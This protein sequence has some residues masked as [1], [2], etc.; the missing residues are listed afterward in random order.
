MSSK[1]RLKTLPQG[2]PYVSPWPIGTRVRIALWQFV[3]LF[4]Y[5]PTPKFFSPWRVL[6]LRIFGAEV[7]GR[8][9]VAASARVRMP[10]NLK[11]EHRACLADACEVYNLAPAVL[12]SGCTVAQ[13]AYL[14]GGTHDLNDPNLPLVVGEIVV[15]KDVF[16]G[17]RA[18]VLPGVRLGDR[19]VV[20]ACAVVTGDVRDNVI[21]AGNPARE[22][23]VRDASRVIS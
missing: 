3:W 13:E 9:F 11:L 2:S 6:L 21:V 20:A 14:C 19:S 17:A 23:G 1:D 18:F 5:R 15:G 12:R 10:W 7:E 16:I 4:L 22:I 8:P